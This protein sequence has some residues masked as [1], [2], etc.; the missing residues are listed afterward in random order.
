MKSKK[1][2]EQDSGF[3]KT[4]IQE[5]I[6]S[7]FD[8]GVKIATILVVDKIRT[9]SKKAQDKDDSQQ[10]AEREK[11]TQRLL[12]IADGRSSYA[13]LPTWKKLFVNKPD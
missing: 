4:G 2:P 3:L 10:R 6:K 13:T 12:K 11:E 9:R 1:S 5:F 8:V 7:G